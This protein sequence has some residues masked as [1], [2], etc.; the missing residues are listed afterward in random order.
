MRL[1]FGSIL[2]AVRAMLIQECGHGAM[3]R[4]IRAA[5]RDTRGAAAVEFALVLPVLTAFLFPVTD[6]GMQGYAEMQLQTAVQSGAHYAVMH[7]WKSSE[8]QAAV[9]NATAWTSIS[10]AAP[11]KACGCAGGTAVTPATCGDVCPNGAPAGTYVT[12]SASLPFTPIFPY[13][14]IGASRT[15]NAQST[16]RIR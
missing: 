3:A 5:L 11:V 9:T 12:V 2:P 13:E 8:I 10:V 15:L 7:G 16:V 4:S 6:L 14:A 1:Q